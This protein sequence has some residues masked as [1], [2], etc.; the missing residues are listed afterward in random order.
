MPEQKDEE[1]LTILRGL[2][3]EAFDELDR[4]EAI[5]I[6][7]EDALAAFIGRIGRRAARR[8]KNRPGSE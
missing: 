2:A 3:A 5:V 7:G 8:V 1:K 6:A 4:G